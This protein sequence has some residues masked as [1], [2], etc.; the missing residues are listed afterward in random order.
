LIKF[1]LVASAAWFV[2]IKLSTVLAI[3]FTMEVTMELHAN[4]RCVMHAALWEPGG[5]QTTRS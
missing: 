1:G 2:A 4:V 5:K 3:C